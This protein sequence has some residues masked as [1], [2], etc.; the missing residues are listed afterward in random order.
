ML[1]FIV[2]LSKLKIKFEV[3]SERFR[4]VDTPLIC[5]DRGL[6]CKDLGWTP[7]YT[8]FDDLKELYIDFLNR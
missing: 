7:M 8:V 1:N 2:G 4:P 6:I 5:C 3:D